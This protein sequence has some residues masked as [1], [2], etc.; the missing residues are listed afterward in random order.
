MKAIV[1]RFAHLDGRFLAMAVSLLFVPLAPAVV[2]L[3]G[4]SLG[5]AVLAMI[6]LAAIGFSA[7]RWVPTYGEELLA[8]VLI[9]QSILVTAQ[10]AGHPWQGDT[11]VIGFA[12]LAIVATMG[13]TSAL[14]LAFG[15][16]MTQIIGLG[17][18]RPEL[19]WPQPGTPDLMRG[20]LNVAVLLLETAVLTASIL[21]RRAAHAAHDKVTQRLETEREIATDTRQEAITSGEQA[22]QVIE[23]LRVAL[24]QLAGRDM[25]CN[26]DTPFPP[27]YEFLRED[28]NS[29]VEILRDA[30]VG[31]NEAAESFTADAQ[32]LSKD[33]VG[34]SRQSGDHVRRLSEMTAATT[35]LLATVAATADQA[36]EA[37][38]AA[39]RARGSAEAG[40]EVTAEAIRAM[41]GIEGSSREISQIVDL[42]DD[43]AFQTNLLALNAGVEAA[44]A[45]QS[46]KGFAVVAAEVRQLA[47]STSEAAA[48][49]RKLISD[50]SDQVK[51]GAGL[52]D[53]VGQRLAEIQEQI[54][55]TSEQTDAISA[56]SAEQTEALTQLHGQVC[57]ADRETQGTA[58]VSEDLAARSR[59]MTMSSKKLSA[60]LEAFTFTEE[61]LMRSISGM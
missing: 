21:Q 59:K 61:D 19:V 58:K 8:A 48:G 29:T 53:A 16:T 26:I 24:A 34:L 20:G 36:K 30:F 44:R 18:L 31:A 57:E 10:F 38:N 4:N 51:S 49:I 55:R 22:K 33:M 47:Q 39:S 56:S 6:A 23:K 27:T 12:M 3:S 32:L 2:Y 35:Q 7:C 28:F 11:H 1:S 43:V 50:S 60:D 40:G 14:F 37:A 15:M 25:T 45:G 5:P 17:L 46:G 52:V 41:R 42:I 9:G 13:R 54:Q